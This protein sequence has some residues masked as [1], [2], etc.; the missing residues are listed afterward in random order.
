MLWNW[1][2]GYWVQDLIFTII[3][4]LGLV[5]KDL[6]GETKFLDQSTSLPMSL[7]IGIKQSFGSFSLL[8]DIKLFEDYSS[9]GVGGEY[10]LGEVGNLRLGYYSEPEFNVDYITIG[11]SID[12][13][14]VDLSLAYYYNTDSFHNETLMISFGF[15]L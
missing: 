13:G 10:L 4:S 3:L 14:I 1:E 6:G 15:D 2:I 7:G 11:G 5:L 9:F 8:S 12:A